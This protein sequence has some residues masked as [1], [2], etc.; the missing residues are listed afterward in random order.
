M[1]R[2]K[3]VPQFCRHCE[4]TLRDYESKLLETV[5]GEKRQKKTRET[6]DQRRAS[7]KLQYKKARDNETDNGVTVVVS[8]RRGV[9][10]SE[11]A[12]CK[13]VY[14]YVPHNGFSSYL[15]A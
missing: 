11:C 7:T 3:W 1:K 4:V 10:A 9:E 8:K 6:A 15:T 14:K 13:Y 2:A 5:E 12:R